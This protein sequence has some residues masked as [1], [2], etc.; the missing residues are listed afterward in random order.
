MVTTRSGFSQ[1]ATGK[2][3]AINERYEQLQKNCIDLALHFENLE[4][5]IAKYRKANDLLSLIRDN[6]NFCEA[7]NACA[8]NL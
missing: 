1:I 8:E 2:A 5:K 7:M 6:P 4:Q 3:E